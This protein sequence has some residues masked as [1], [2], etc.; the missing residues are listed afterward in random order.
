MGFAKRAVSFVAFSVL[1]S[2]YVLF[3]KK[4]DVIYASSTPLTVGIPALTGKWLRRIP[5]VFEVRDQ[6][7]E[8]PI[9]LGIIKNK[10][11][12]KFLL[13]L[14]KT[15]YRNSSAIIACS[16]GQ[17]EGVRTVAG[18]GKRVEVVSNSCDIELFKPDI[19][20][21][22]IRSKHNWGDK[23]V[24]LHAGAMGKVNSLHF[25]IDAAE[26]LKD[27]KNIL[28]V[29]LGQG[30]EK[31]SLEKRVLELNLDNVQILPSV[32]KYILPNYF[33]AIDV[34]MVIIGG[35]PII[36]HNS[37]NKFFD[38]LSAGKPVLLNYSGWQR[39]IIEDNEA[40][41]GCKLCDLSEFIDRVI[42]YYK[43]RNNIIAMGRNAR[44][45]ALTQF[46]RNSLA[47][48]ALKIIELAN[49]QK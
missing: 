49:S 29:L 9:E 47:R 8:I 20:G 4:P 25:I 10:I 1:S 31:P 11:V 44:E 3:T 48:K 18:E 35:Y 30:K 33:A 21:S 46:D 45:L 38:S 39:K 34:S 40:G 14:E 43:N 24:F 13:W 19:D 36:E 22:H 5:F 37:A 16:P 6:W 26:K 17:A 42:Y 27:N 2:L 28:F 32:A 15:L 23:L 12:I 7:P 41:L